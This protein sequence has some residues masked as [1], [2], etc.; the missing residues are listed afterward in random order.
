MP[1]RETVFCINANPIPGRTRTWVEAVGMVAP[2]LRYWR[3][4][5]APHAPSPFLELRPF[6][7]RKRTEPIDHRADSLR[8]TPRESAPYSWQD[9]FSLMRAQ[10]IEDPRLYATG[11]PSLSRKSY[12]SVFVVS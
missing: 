9:I 11:A 6:V 7:D 12:P 10:S 8:H 1:P 5:E 3:S 2:L 4:G